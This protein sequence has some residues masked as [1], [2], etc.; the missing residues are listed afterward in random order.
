MA[1]GVLLGAGAV[2][3]GTFDLI[4]VANNQPAVLKKVLIHGGVNTTVVIAYSILTYMAFKK[5][6]GLVSDG[7]LK[8]IIKGC[9]VAFMIIGNYIGGSLV[10]KDKIGVE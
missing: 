7:L 5:Y 3:T 4:G 10:L 8:I 9:L 2:I 6:P 1:G